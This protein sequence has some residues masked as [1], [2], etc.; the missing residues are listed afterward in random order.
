MLSLCFSSLGCSD[1]APADFCQRAARHH[2]PLVEIRSLCGLVDFPGFLAANPSEVRILEGALAEHGIGLRLLASSF[3]LTLHGEDGIPALTEVG[4]VAD[5]LAVPF[6]RIFGGGRDGVILSR[7]E[8]MAAASLFLK[9]R[10]SWN[11]E[12][13]ESRILV[14]THGGLVTAD[15]IRAFDEATGGD[16][17]YLWDSHHT[18]KLG[19]AAPGETAELIGGRVRHIHYKD[20]VPDPGEKHGYRYVPP[21]LGGFPI[22]DLLDTMRA[23]DAEVALSLEW[24]RKWH[25]ELPPLDEALKAFRTTITDLFESQ[26]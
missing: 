25:P 8:V 5:T 11:D 15:A 12:G 3:S 19:G 14:E 17:E 7:G 9:V 18:W 10:A 16:A 22:R 4:H 6:V 20:S 24:E 26:K 2:I 1:D 13:I 23:F 21:G